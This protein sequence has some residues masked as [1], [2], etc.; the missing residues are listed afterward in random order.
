MYNNRANALL[1]A[2]LLTWIVV[3][4]VALVCVNARRTSYT[5]WD[6]REG[7][8]AAALWESLLGGIRA[9]LSN[10]QGLFGS[11]NPVVETVRS[12]IIT[13]S[14]VRINTPSI[15]TVQ[16]KN[17]LQNPRWTDPAMNASLNTDTVNPSGGWVLNSG[18]TRLRATTLFGNALS[19]TIMGGAVPGIQHTV[20]YCDPAVDTNRDVCT[21]Q[22]PLFVLGYVRR[23]DTTASGNAVL[24]VI[25]TPLRGQTPIT[26]SALTNTI[27]VPPPSGSNTAGWIYFG[28]LVVPNWFDMSLDP[29]INSWS[30]E[31]RNTTSGTTL[32]IGDVMVVDSPEYV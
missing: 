3:L 14:A 2:T 18:N 15:V 4:S 1:T 19:L 21:P 31:F 27:D 25:R 32:A 11:S 26:T 24:A 7:F 8:D 17:W 10:V 30:L 29:H 6:S 28:P 22:K 16:T 20:Q 5:A 13:Q 23:S 9:F 12:A